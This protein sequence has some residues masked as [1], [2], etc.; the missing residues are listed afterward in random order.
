MNAQTRKTGHRAAHR[1]AKAV[2]AN[3][4]SPPD[5]LTK[6]PTPKQKR[7]I[8]LLADYVSFVKARQEER[9][10]AGGI[11]RMAMRGFPVITP[12][13]LLDPSRDQ[14]PK[15]KKIIPAIRALKGQHDLGVQSYQNVG[16]LL[17][18]LRRVAPSRAIQNAVNDVLFGK[19]TLDKGFKH[20]PA[21]NYE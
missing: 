18:S 20:G 8:E 3:F 19:P 1:S 11:L 7:A 9:R 13:H 2:F 5:R 12:S 14:Y 16:N 21:P 6:K 10:H 4:A 15:K 17:L